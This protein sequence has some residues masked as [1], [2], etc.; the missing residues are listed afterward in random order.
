MGNG[1]IGDPSKA[2]LEKGKIF[3]EMA[4]QG[5][6]IALKELESYPEN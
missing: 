6:M 2:S 4:V 5:V 1:I 3:F